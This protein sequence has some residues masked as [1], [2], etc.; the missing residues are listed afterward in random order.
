MNRLVERFLFEWNDERFP[1]RFNIAPSQPVATLRRDQSDSPHRL[2]MARWGLIPSWAKDPTIGNR[3]INARGETVAEKASFRSAFRR[4]R[5]LVLTDG[6]YEWKPGGPEGKKQP[7]YFTMQDEQPFA[8]AGVWES[9][10]SPDGKPV[11]TCTIITTD[12]NRLA[13]PIHHRMPVIIDDKDHELWL[14]PTED[15]AD[16]LSRLLVPFAP[17]PMR[18][19]KV[20]TLVNNPRNEKPDCI[21]PLVDDGSPA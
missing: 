4:R 1:P 20:S 6:Y 9:W 21:T 7:F 12:A 3:L 18:V 8:M 14:D 19:Q 13:R 2:A 5:C 17:D 15:R 16:C 10:N 11:E